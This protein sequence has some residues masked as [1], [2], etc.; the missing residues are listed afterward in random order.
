MY[1]AELNGTHLLRDIIVNGITYEKVWSIEY[2][3]ERDG[4]TVCL[5]T[6]TSRN[7]YVRLP[8]DAIVEVV[9]ED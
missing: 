8:L 5:F 3:V 2:N 1:A 6:R 7:D 4:A 9:E